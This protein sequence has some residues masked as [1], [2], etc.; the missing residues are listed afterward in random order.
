MFFSVVLQ[1][2]ASVFPIRGAGHKTGVASL[3]RSGGSAVFRGNE[4][5]PEVGHV[6][7][8][9]TGLFAPPF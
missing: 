8:V 5:W 4:V 9:L 2:V 1:L 7:A 6:G 3:S